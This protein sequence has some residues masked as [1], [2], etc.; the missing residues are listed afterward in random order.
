M[1]LPP[2]LLNFMFVPTLIFCFL[3]AAAW[4]AYLNHDTASFY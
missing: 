2:H 1:K 3:V 4:L